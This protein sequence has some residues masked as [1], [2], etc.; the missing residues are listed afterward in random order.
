MQSDSGSSTS[1]T[2]ERARDR[3]SGGESPRTV[4]RRLRFLPKTSVYPRHYRPSRSAEAVKV[5]PGVDW[6]QVAIGGIGVDGEVVH[7]EQ[8]GHRQSVELVVVRHGDAPGTLQAVHRQ[9]GEVGVVLHGDVIAHVNQVGHRQRGELEVALHRDII[10]HVKQA[11]QVD[12]SA[13]VAANQIAH[14]SVTPSLQRRCQSYPFVSPITMCRRCILRLR[15]LLEPPAPALGHGS[16]PPARAAR[17][18][19]HL[20]VDEVH[21]AGP[22]GEELGTARRLKAA[23]LR[24]PPDGGVR[25]VIAVGLLGVE[26][27]ATRLRGVARGRPVDDALVVRVGALGGLA[28]CKERHRVVADQDAVDAEGR[29]GCR[30]C[31]GWRRSR[32][33]GLRSRSARGCPHRRACR[34]PPRFPRA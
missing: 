3:S 29:P 20:G 14:H 15:L 17:H 5:L 16:R 28:L 18:R 12:V 23:R 30:R 8:A 27:A 7:T 9:R 25:E 32:R 1:S 26:L 6:P 24:R 10:E 34:L 13:C 22:F 2:S 33:S 11:G 31:G 19:A 21:L 4:G